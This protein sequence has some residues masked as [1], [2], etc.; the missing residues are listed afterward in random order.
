M[1]S[2][3]ITSWYL[4]LKIVFVVKPTWWIRL[5][6]IHI[7]HTNWI[8]VD[9]LKII[10]IIAK[11]LCYR[12]FYHSLSIRTVN[13]QFLTY[14]WR[15]RNRIPYRNH[16]NVNWTCKSKSGTRTQLYRINSMNRRRK[17][18]CNVTKIETN[19]HTSKCRWYF[20][21]TNAT[22]I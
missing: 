8:N 11:P 6:N 18:C 19:Q 20:H 17:S 1:I 22:N 13:Q 14:W 7:Y 3:Y 5:H 4:S 12:L 9:W 2:Y 16:Q 21:L 15:F 10:G